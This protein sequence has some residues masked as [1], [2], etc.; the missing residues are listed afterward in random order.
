MDYCVICLNNKNTKDNNFVLN[1]S[2]DA[3]KKL[4]VRAGERHNYKDSEVTE[5]AEHTKSVIAR[6]LFDQHAQYYGSC[7]KSITNIK[8]VQRAQKMLF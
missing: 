6:E 1:P 3:F 2:L 8:K 5:F 7:Y 4:L